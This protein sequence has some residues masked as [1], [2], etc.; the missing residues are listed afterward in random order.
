MRKLNKKK[1]FVSD[2]IRFKPYKQF[3]NYDKAYTSIANEVYGILR[4]HEDWFNGFGYQAEYY[5]ELAI[6]ITSYFED[7]INEIG[8]WKAFIKH[9]KRE[10]GYYLPFYALDEYDPEYLNPEDFMFL[11]WHHMGM[12]REKLYGPDAPSIQEVGH[13][14]YDLLE[15]K[16]EEVPVTGF[17]QSYLNIPDDINFFALKN[18][19]IWFAMNSY[20]L[21][22]EFSSQL[23]RNIEEHL[24]QHPEMAEGGRFKPIFYTFQDDF[25]YIRRSA[26]SALTTLEWF[27]EIAV[28]SPAMKQ[29]IY[30]LRKRI[31]GTFLYE[32]RTE[33]HYLFEHIQSEIKIK[34]IR[35]S[36][37]IGSEAEKGHLCLFSI[38]PWQGEWWLTGSFMSYG[39]IPKNEIKDMKKDVQN[40]PFYIYSKEQQDRLIQD[41]K[42][43][44]TQFLEFFGQDIVFFKNQK[45][46]TKALQANNDA[47]N[48]KYATEMSEERKKEIE[49]RYGSSE[50]RWEPTDFEIKDKEGL[51]V[52]FVSGQGVIIEPGVP[53]V[54]NL[55][56]KEE[57]KEKQDER[58]LFDIMLYELH[59]QTVKYLLDN[60]PTKNLKF[61]IWVSEIDVLKNFGF[62]KRYYK[63]EDYAEP[64]PN[65][66]LFL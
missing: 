27:R 17:Y 7:F 66:R 35:E 41:T 43:M 25:L 8:I 13:E 9:N 12:E 10:L 50:N 6:I 36:V 1:I 51:A 29:G 49:E 4:K 24:E 40:T 61:P 3:T 23:A 62:L 47:Y 11:L 55:L 34:V 37:T 56:K 45:E 64:I 44:E 42:N 54:I 63:P 19:L 65:T 22:P 46:M 59:P 33:T 38:V 53:I 60:Y 14:L 28:C 20:L 48:I 15:P 2:W 18:K 21:G 32:S 57:L 58:Q 30:E 39:E 52:R 16:I 5:K 26:L 31:L